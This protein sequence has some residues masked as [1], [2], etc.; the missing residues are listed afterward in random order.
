M[1]DRLNEDLNAHPLASIAY[2]DNE[3]KCF[4]KAETKS[5]LIREELL[6]M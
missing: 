1:H 5:M 6:G 3:W 2:A 4:K